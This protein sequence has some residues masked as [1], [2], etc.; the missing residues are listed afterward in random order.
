MFAFLYLT[1]ATIHAAPTL[2]ADDKEEAFLVR[3]IAEYWKD[4]DFSVVKAQ[5]LDFLATHPKSKM[6]DHL[7]GILADLWLQ[8]GNYNEALRIY[9]Q[10]QAPQVIEKVALNKLQCLYELNAFE[11]MIQEGGRFLAKPTPD[12]EVRKQE[13]HFLM[14][15]GFFRLGLTHAKKEELVPFFRVTVC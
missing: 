1:V 5:I 8:E 11:A 13:F 7:K 6:T 2:P 12:M 14:A 15:E 3:R 10:I 4:Q 9:N